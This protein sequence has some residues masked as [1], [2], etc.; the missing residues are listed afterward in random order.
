MPVACSFG[1]SR[2]IDFQLVEQ[3]ARLFESQCPQVQNGQ[4]LLRL[5]CVDAVFGEVLEHG[6]PRVFI[7]TQLAGSRELLL[8]GR[9]SRDA[10]L[11]D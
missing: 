4:S 8:R 9:F 2:P 10:V 1:F 11:L 3:L 6:F 7:G 5:H